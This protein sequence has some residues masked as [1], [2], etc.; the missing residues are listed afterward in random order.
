MAAGGG[1]EDT[2]AA[3]LVEAS[4]GVVS[5]LESTYHDVT[6]LLSKLAVSPAGFS[7][8]EEAEMAPHKKVGI[9]GIGQVGMACAF[10]MMNQVRDV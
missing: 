6:G 1:G 5:E 7:R 10:A 4:S 2:P 8:S 9:I 3:S